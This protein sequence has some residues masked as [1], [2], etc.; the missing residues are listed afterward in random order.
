MVFKFYG[1]QKKQDLRFYLSNVAFL[2]VTDAL[3]EKIVL[4][5]HHFKIVTRPK[6]SLDKEKI[7]KHMK[8]V[9]E[10]E[11]KKQE[12]NITNIISS[13]FTLTMKQIKSLKQEVND[14]KEN[15]EFTQNDL[16]EKVADGEKKSPR[17]KSK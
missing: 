4:I 10:E 8:E 2:K 13:N 9:F 1:T 17:L 12:V 7:A 5:E 3:G 14:L 6:I 15:I 11:F 16:E